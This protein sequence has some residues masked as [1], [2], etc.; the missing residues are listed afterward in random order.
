MKNI[1]KNLKTTLFGTI[2]GVPTIIEGAQSHNLG[3]ILAGLGALL[4]GL[5]AKDH[6]SE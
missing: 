3:H 6:T 1:W 4:L 2:A 5:F